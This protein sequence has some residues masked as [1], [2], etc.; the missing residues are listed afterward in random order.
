MKPFRLFII[1]GVLFLLATG[2]WYSSASSPVDK[3]NSTKQQFSVEKGMGVKAIGAKLE[4]KHL[5]RNSLI[6]YITVKR[7][8]IENKIQTGDFQ[9]SPSQT[10]A[11]IA[12]NLTK[13]ALD[14]WVTIPEGKRAEEVAQILKETL[15]NYETT[16]Q[17]QLKEHEGYLF[18]DTYLIPKDATIDQIISVL[19][20]TFDQKYSTVTN[21]TNF[22]KIKVVT[23]ASLIEREARKDEDRPL[24]SSVMHNRLDIG[25]PLQIDATVQYALGYDYYGKS[26]WKKELSFDDLKLNSP[27]NTYVTPGL[28]PTPI[29]SPGIK[30]LE[31][32][33]NPANTPYLFYITDKNGDN[34]YAKTLTE[35]NANIKKYGL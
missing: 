15:P 9:I 16:W 35:H 26:W 28:P 30:A 7:L 29:A 21:N 25:M 8:G 19:T 10:T 34:H 1:V 31:A 11:E 4:S 27:Y 33:A 12:E 3:T 24:V 14:I 2:F 23:L 20:D 22:S 17:T 6:F 18:P 5:I 32:A 13:G